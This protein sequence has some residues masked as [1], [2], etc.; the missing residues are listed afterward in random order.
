MSLTD[1]E[2]FLYG[3][4]YNEEIRGR[5]LKIAALPECERGEAI[6]GLGYSFS[7]GELDSAVCREF[8][9][10]LEELRD[11]LG[12]GDLRDTVMRMWGNYM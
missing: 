9:R 12:P 8:Y 1:A 6:R 3:I 7:P 5:C 4:I 10:M 2:H 11:I